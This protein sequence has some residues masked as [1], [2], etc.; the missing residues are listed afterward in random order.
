MDG[1]S[2]T[3]NDG[4][5]RALLSRWCAPPRP[6]APPRAPHGRMHRRRHG[7]LPWPDASVRP[8]TAGCAAAAMA[9]SCSS[10][11]RTPSSPSSLCA[12]T[13]A[14]LA[15]A[16]GG[17]SSMGR[18]QRP[19]STTSGAPLSSATCAA[20]WSAPACGSLGG[21]HGARGVQTTATRRHDA[22]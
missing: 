8:L 2:S 1:S 18:R 7:L 3:G 19:F 6:D 9:S 14:A 21:A 20:R 5:R 12:A 11:S 15:P 22:R 17:G 16:P 4:H 13:A 10:A